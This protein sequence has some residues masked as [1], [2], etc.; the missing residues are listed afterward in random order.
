[1]A[2]TIFSHTFD[3]L[4]PEATLNGASPDV[5]DHDWLGS[6][7]FLYDADRIVYDDDSSLGIIKNRITVDADADK[8]FYFCFSTPDDPAID[9]AVVIFREYEGNV[10]L[11][12]QAEAE[13]LKIYKIIA[14]TPTLLSTIS[15][16]TLDNNEIICIKIN[17]AEGSELFDFHYKQA[18]LPTE[19]LNGE[20][21]SEP[22]EIDFNATLTLDFEVGLYHGISNQADSGHFFQVHVTEGED[23]GSGSGEG[24]SCVLDFDSQAI[25]TSASTG[26]DDFELDGAFRHYDTFDETVG[27]ACVHYLICDPISH[28]FERGRGFHDEGILERLVVYQSSNANAKVSFNAGTKIVSLYS[29]KAPHAF[30]PRFNYQ[31]AIYGHTDVQ[32][33]QL[34]NA[35]LGP[36]SDNNDLYASLP[37]GE[38]AKPFHKGQIAHSSG[39]SVAEQG[40]FQTTQDTL[41]GI[42]VNTASTVLKRD[43]TDLYTIPNNTLL[44][45]WIHIAAY[46][47]DKSSGASFLRQLV[48]HNNAGTVALIGSVQTIGTDNNAPGFSI[49]LTADNTN[50]ALQIQVTGVSSKTTRWTAHVQATVVAQT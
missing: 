49:A 5:G 22:E 38:Y 8:T 47:T 3:D 40:A 30:P 41:M 16:P 25:E 43:G 50:D 11:Y 44:S 27:T 32:G 35:V 39:N 23:S 26:L 17:W 10:Y 42:T 21:W 29:L 15:V 36:N 12:V 33:Y 46:H 45:L 20:D 28:Q 2:T 14:G 6:V 48:I 19:L 34:Y 24:A 13:E 31:P 37:I 18:T 7:S 9:T 1:M 4:P